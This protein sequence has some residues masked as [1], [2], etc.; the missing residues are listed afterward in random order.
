MKKRQKGLAFIAHQP[1][2]SPFTEDEESPACARLGEVLRVE[3]MHR[4]K[5]GYEAFYC[6]ADRGGGMLFAEQV[7]QVKNTEYPS[8]RLICVIPY[9]NRAGRWPERGRERYFRLLEQASEEVLISRRY[10]RDCYERQNRYIV[11]QAN[12]LLAVYNGSSKGGAARTLEY[13]GSRAKEIVLLDPN[14][15]ARTVIPPR[16]ALVPPGNEAEGYSPSATIFSSA[17][18]RS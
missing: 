12:V 17:A 4:A 10:T 15:L 16:L 2:S 7:L 14:T 3:I 8:I 11:D 13:A 5:Q 6:G 9:E 18:I 1:K